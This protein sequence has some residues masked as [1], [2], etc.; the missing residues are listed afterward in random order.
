MGRSRDELKPHLDI[1]LEYLNT[2]AGWILFGTNIYQF[3]FSEAKDQ[4]AV[5]LMQEIIRAVEKETPYLSGNFQLKPC[6]AL[7]KYRWQPYCYTDIVKSAHIKNKN[8]IDRILL[9]FDDLCCLLEF[10]KYT[11]SVDKYLIE[12]PYLLHFFIKL[13]AITL[14]E[15]FDNF[16][17]YIN[18]VSSCDADAILLRTILEGT[19]DEY[20]QHCAIL[21]NNL[22][23]EIQM[24]YSLSDSQTLYD[25]L[26]YSLS[27]VEL[28]Y[29]R[30]LK[31]LS[32]SPSKL[33]FFAYRFLQWV[34]S[35]NR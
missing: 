4:A 30:I 18:H 26:R 5:N 31:T 9:A 22:H 29:T 19:N 8:I 6:A 11:I 2:D 14:D 10:F 34:Q 27:I 7:P 32:I 25:E 1:C 13:I 33:R 17:K 16:N 28:L 35:P 15:T 12:A 21:R 20:L 23:Y 3:H 24:S